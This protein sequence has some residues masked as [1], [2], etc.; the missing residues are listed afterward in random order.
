MECLGKEPG[1]RRG[2]PLEA[3]RTRLAPFW[4]PPTLRGAPPLRGGGSPARAR[5]GTCRLLGVW[6]KQDATIASARPN[7][8]RSN[9]HKPCRIPPDA[10]SG[11]FCGCLW[12]LSSNEFGAIYVQSQS[13]ARDKQ[14]CAR[15]IHCCGDFWGGRHCTQ[16]SHSQKNAVRASHPGLFLCCLR[17]KS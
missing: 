2:P 15:S 14:V 12:D 10:L 4:S 6:T 1:P 9:Q 7:L 8:E 3:I 5:A 16:F 11:V 17:G 13:E